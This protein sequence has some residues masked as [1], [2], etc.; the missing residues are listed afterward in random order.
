MTG[1]RL[2]YWYI[3]RRYGGAFGFNTEVGPGPQIPPLSKHQEDDP[4]RRSC[5]RSTTH[6]FITAAGIISRTWTASWVR[7]TPGTANRTTL[8]ISCS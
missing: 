1:L 5:G 3:D 6:G 4:G 2:I 7:S 8:R